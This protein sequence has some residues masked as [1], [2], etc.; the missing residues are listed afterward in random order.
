MGKFGMKNT[1]SFP[2]DR[3][4]AYDKA[5]ENVVFIS[6]CDEHHWKPRIDA[7]TL[8]GNQLDASDLF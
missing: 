4:H 6:T 5:Q 7:R 8:L 2:Y 3:P 1:D